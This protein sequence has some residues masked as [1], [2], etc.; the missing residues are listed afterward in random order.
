[1]MLPMTIDRKLVLWLLWGVVLALAAVGKIWLTDPMSRFILAFVSLWCL[2][3][4][5]TRV[6]W[7]G[8]K[9]LSSPR[10]S[11]LSKHSR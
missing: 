3:A 4:L 1:M 2:V 6:R 5:G 10:A 11:I 9:G 7:P 8:H